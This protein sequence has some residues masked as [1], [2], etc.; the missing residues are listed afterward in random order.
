[1][2]S[3]YDDLGASISGELDVEAVARRRGV[4]P[5]EASEWRRLFLAGARAARAGRRAR[6]RGRLFKLA[7]IGAVGLVL[8]VAREASSSACVWDLPGPLST[9]CQDGPAVAHKLNGNFRQIA[10]WLEGKIGPAGGADVIAHDISAK[11]VS[12]SGS[13]KVRERPV[14]LDVTACAM[15]SSVDCCPKGY[16]RDGQELNANAPACWF[17]E[18]APRIFLCR[19]YAR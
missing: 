18:A 11:N 8:L 4:P 7:G 2:H 13:L 19:S 1:M 17:G 15:S 5:E 6:L 16:E 3:K 10:D 12:A 14:T 9:L